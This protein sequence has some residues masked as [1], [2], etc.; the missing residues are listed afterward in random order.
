MTVDGGYIVLT[1]GVY[2][3]DGQFVSE[4]VELDIASCGDTLDEAF[5]NIRE[6]VAIYLDTLEQEGERERVFGER[7]IGVHP[8]EPPEDIEVPVSA[9]PH[10]Y[11][12][13]EL[14]PIPA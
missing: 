7:G 13:P 11:V 4:C 3:E 12:S 2:E 8:G 6:A 14:V 9:R 1:L 5:K 10:E